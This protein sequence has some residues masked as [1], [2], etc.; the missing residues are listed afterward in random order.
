MAHQGISSDGYL[1]QHPGGVIKVV[2]N[3]NGGVLE[4]L[5]MGTVQHSRG[6]V[7]A[8]FVAIEV[9]ILLVTYCIHSFKAPTHL[10]VV[11]SRLWSETMRNDER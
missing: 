7:L 6:I 8:L 3:V 11:F 9:N 10:F 5:M 4:Q 1:A 2:T